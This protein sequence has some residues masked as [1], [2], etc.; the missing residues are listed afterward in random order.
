MK[1]QQNPRGAQITLKPETY[2][3]AVKLY[4]GIVAYRKQH[5]F[6]PAIRDLMPAINVNTTSMVSYYLRLLEAWGCIKR[7]HGSARTI[8]AIHPP[9]PTS[10]S[11]R[12][13]KVAGCKQPVWHGPRGMNMLLRRCEQ[14]EREAWAIE[15]KAREPVRVERTNIIRLPRRRMV[16]GKVTL[17]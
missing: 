1:E 3:R 17:E 6:P 14:H 11:H 16:F 7:V 15:D 2:G 4:H 5:G 13:C 8:V 12:Q 9:T 10:A